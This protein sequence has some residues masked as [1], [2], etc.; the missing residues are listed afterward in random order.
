MVPC[1]LPIIASF[2]SIGL[3]CCACI[4]EYKWYHK[5]IMGD[6]IMA[7]QNNSKNIRKLQDRCFE[8]IYL[9]RIDN[10]NGH[11][12]WDQRERKIKTVRTVLE[13]HMS[14]HE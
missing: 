2:G 3:H 4:S 7:V 12:V 5:H 8:A 1:K 6:S 11:L 9:C 10:G 14:W 13:K